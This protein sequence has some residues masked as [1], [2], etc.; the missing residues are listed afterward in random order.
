VAGVD[1]S[2]AR[3]VDA[4]GR[5]G[6]VVYP[7]ETLYGLGAD[8]LDR[9]AIE[10]VAAL[11]GR[12]AAKPI[13]LVVASRCM[14]LTIVAMIPSSAEL[15]ME[16]FWP[17]PLTLVL[18]PRAGLSPLLGAGIGARIPA[19]P[20]ARRIVESFGRPMT[21]TSANPGG[22]PAPRTAEGARVYFGDR[23]DVYVDGGETPGGPGS[24][25]LDVTGP[26]PRLVREGEILRAA[27]E[28]A[29]RNRVEG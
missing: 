7:T 29:L 22:E 3:A 5:R 6:V 25:V 20:V 10:R 24:T 15:L 14:L 26:V 17:G 19:H 28:A 27:I 12:D 8:A 13:S 9:A 16:R 4:L 23:I 18:P 2:I 11:K 1:E 21:A